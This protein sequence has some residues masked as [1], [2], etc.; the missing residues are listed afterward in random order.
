[1]A[2]TAGVPRVAALR[3]ALVE[4]LPQTVVPLVR[5]ILMCL[6]LPIRLCVALL[7]AAWGALFAV[8]DRMGRRCCPGLWDTVKRAGAHCSGTC[9]YASSNAVVGIDAAVESEAVARVKKG[10]CSKSLRNLAED[11][12]KQYEEGG[13]KHQGA[14]PFMAVVPSPQERGCIVNPDEAARSYSSVSGIAGDGMGSV[15]SMLHAEKAWSPSANVAG[16]WMQMDLPADMMVLG[17]VTQ[18]GRGTND[19]VTKYS[20]QYRSGDSRWLNLQETFDTDLSG[21]AEARS[22]F[23]SPILARQL[24]ILVLQWRGQI[25]LRAGILATSDSFDHA[26]AVLEA[27]VHHLDGWR[28]PFKELR[29]AVCEEICNRVQACAAT[30]PDLDGEAAAFLGREEVNLGKETNDLQQY[31]RRGFFAGAGR[32]E[33]LVSYVGLVETVGAKLSHPGLQ[34]AGQQLEDVVRQRITWVQ[35]RDHRALQFAL[36]CASALRQQHL[37]DVKNAANRYKDMRGLPEDWDVLGMASENAYGFRMLQKVKISGCLLGATPMPGTLAATLQKLLD[38]TYVA[39]FTRDRRDGSG[40]PHRLVLVSAT[41]VQNEQSWVEY[42]R[43][44]EEIR[45]EIRGQP[46]Q[47]HESFGPAMPPAL[48]MRAEGIQRLGNL[49]NEVQETWLYH[50]TT[51]AGAEGISTEDFRISLAGSAAGTLYGRGVYLAE[52]CTKSDEY[53]KEEYLG[54]DRYLLLCRA[55]IGRVFYTDKSHNDPNHLEELCRS[56]GFHC[57]LGDREK[58][59]GTYRE[60]IVYDDDQVYP[61][62]V[63]CYRRQ[64]YN[65]KDTV[66]R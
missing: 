48:P 41:A 53:T 16:E 44:R 62:F 33:I 40:V 12:L 27:A 8:L 35:G 28:T 58:C 25:R 24:R 11:M 26:V 38:E 4:R 51:Q 29:G 64:K 23:P 52:A 10:R 13:F 37:S 59:R 56:G 55:T 18:A 66:Q 54:T 2:E 60:F 63:L 22:V 7:S 5:P 14:H 32:M 34:P 45:E 15:Q 47:G 1:M 21:E 49:D 20:V 46:L 6:A 61:A 31:E 3:Q 50:G 57:V 36:L 39:K 65:W 43:R 19:C 30:T 42:I 9:W 17:V